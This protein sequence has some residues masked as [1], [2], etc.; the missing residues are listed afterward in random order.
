MN[1]RIVPQ[2]N[3]I[4]QSSS[5]VADDAYSLGSTFTLQDRVEAI[6]HSSDEFYQMVS[7]RSALY[8][9]KMFPPSSREQ[10]FSFPC[11]NVY[12]IFYSY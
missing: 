3:L 5:S 7:K 12:E 2:D 4:L 8:G 9:R 11:S 6:E 10:G 1:H